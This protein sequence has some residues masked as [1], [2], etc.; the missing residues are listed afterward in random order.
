M[1]DL[2]TPTW[3][4]WVTPPPASAAVGTVITVTCKVTLADG[5]TPV[6]GGIV[7]FWANKPGDAYWGYADVGTDGSGQASYSY[8]IDREGT[9]RMFWYF[10]DT[11]VYV[12]SRTEEATVSTGAGPSPIIGWMPIA[13]AVGVVAVV[14]VI[15]ALTRR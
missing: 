13:A 3:T 7:Q 11:T 15:Y 8:T 10:P 14:G 1:I 9:F 6:V 4:Q 12:G 5:V 2:A